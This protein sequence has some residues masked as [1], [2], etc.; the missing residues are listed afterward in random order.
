[1]HT[2]Q[3][4]VGMSVPSACVR[5]LQIAMLIITPHL[6]MQKALKASYI[7]LVFVE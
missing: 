4:L 5:T 3:V 7:C 2:M 1:M 6:Y